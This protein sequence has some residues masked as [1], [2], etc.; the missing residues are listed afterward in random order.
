[1]RHTD[2][3][4]LEHLQ[5]ASVA[6]LSPSVLHR[7]ELHQAREFLTDQLVY[8][9]TSYLQA[10]ELA[11]VTKDF[12]YETWASWWQH[13]KH[14]LFPTFSTWARRPPVKARH[15]VTVQVRNW[16]TFPESTVVYPKDLGPVRIMQRA[17]IL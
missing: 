11:P 10:D 4:T 5:V 2:I 1:M 13:T 3:I 8:R 12:T 15:T 9:L 16:A 14:A 7:M 17:E 6:A